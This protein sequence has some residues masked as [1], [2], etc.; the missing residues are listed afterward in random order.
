MIAGMPVDLCSSQTF[1]ASLYATANT[2]EDCKD[3]P[4]GFASLLTLALGVLRPQ[5]QKL[6]K[7]AKFF[8]ISPTPVSY[9]QL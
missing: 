8:Q 2:K 7:L 6:L 1:K 3:P 5:R 4:K 9:E